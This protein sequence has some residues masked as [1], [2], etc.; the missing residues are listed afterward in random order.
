MR[1]I[2]G[3]KNLFSQARFA[4][5]PCRDNDFLP[6]V[7]RRQ[8]LA[9]Y[10]LFFFA[11][12][13]VIFPFWYAFPKSSFFAEVIGST[14][15][16]LTNKDR[17]AFGLQP[18]KVNPVLVQAASHKAKDMID[19]DYFAHISP[20]GITPWY[21]FKKIGYSYQIA[22]ENLAI[23]FVDSAEVETA[24][25]NSP[26]HRQNLLNPNFKEIGIAVLSGEFQGKQA[27]VVVQ[28]FGNPVIKAQVIKPR[29]S[30][31]PLVG[32]I[33]IAPTPKQEVL[34]S[35]PTNVLGEEQQPVATPVEKKSVPEA[36]LDFG[37]NKYDQLADILTKFFLLSVIFLLVLTLCVRLL[38]GIKSWNIAFSLGLFLILFF[39]SDLIDKQTII[40]L[41][42]HNLI[43]NG[44]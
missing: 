34:V 41:I 40:N 29:A 12:E 21:W 43:I 2:F 3:F 25:K 35:P 42:P 30:P 5:W 32:Q 44:F 20:T 37:A 27:T 17:L 7:L 31:S 8:F 19:N 14:L 10:I 13:L 6:L 4:L 28:F 16:D 22:G 1:A 33:S 9:F 18:L 15:V 24:W 38:E 39:I 26:S 23:G 36:V 11:T